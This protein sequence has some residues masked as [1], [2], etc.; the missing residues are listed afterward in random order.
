MP[1]RFYEHPHTVL[2]I[3]NL[4][5]M[6]APQL[7]P[8]EGQP[9]LVWHTLRLAGTSSYAYVE[10]IEAL[11]PVLTQGWQTRPNAKTGN[12]TVVQPTAL[13]IY[14]EDHEFMLERRHSHGGHAPHRVRLH[15]RLATVARPDV[16]EVQGGEGAGA[17]GAQPRPGG[18]LL[19]LQSYGQDPGLEIVQRL[20]PD[21]NPFMVG[22]RDL[23]QA[24]ETAL[25]SDAQRLHPR[26]AA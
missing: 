24:L 14:R 23:L 11:G 8:K 13:V 20:W 16:G 2:V 18:R 6:E 25:G 17:A 26:G 22:R 15:S 7:T 12:P 3:T 4:S 5:Y 9:P 10:Q 21:E 1:D 19:T